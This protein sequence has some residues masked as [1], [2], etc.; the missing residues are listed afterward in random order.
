MRKRSLVLSMQV[1][2]KMDSLGVFFA[3]RQRF[4]FFSFCPLNDDHQSCL[5][6]K[7]RDILE[8]RRFLLFLVGAGRDP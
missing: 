4:L 5:Y 7:M 6:Y 1:L 2:A 3:K 8:H